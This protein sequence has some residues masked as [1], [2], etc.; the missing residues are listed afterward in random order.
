MTGFWN[1]RYDRSEFV[2]GKEPN[3]FFAE[4]LSQL[5]KQDRTLSAG[6]TSSAEWRPRLLLPMEGE[7]RNAVYAAQQGWS[8]DASDFSTVAR[9]KAY[10]L[11]NLAGVSIN[12][13]IMD[14]TAPSLRY[15]RYQAAG[16]IYAHLSPEYRKFLHREIQKSLVPEGVVIIEAFHVSQLGNPSGGPGNVDMLYTAD[17]LES[18]FEGCDII[19]LD[20]TQTILQEGDGHK[21]PAQIVRGV[22]KKR[23]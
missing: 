3:Q 20:E 11:S 18:D 5:F 15:N 19:E 16:L 2:Y 10:E 21:G 23:I 1:E 8:V 22:F 12:Y 7:G 14:M 13:A 4:Q 9:N 17:I 6:K